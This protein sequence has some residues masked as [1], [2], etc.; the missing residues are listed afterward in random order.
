MTKIYCFADFSP[1]AMGRV[2]FCHFFCHMQK[3][4]SGTFLEGGEWEHATLWAIS[5]IDFF[6]YLSRD[7][8][9]MSSLCGLAIYDFG[10]VIPE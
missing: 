4:H 5:S 3:N 10:R 1:Q 7:F 2:I 6:L 8:R 9:E